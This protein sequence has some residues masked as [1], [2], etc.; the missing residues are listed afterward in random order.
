MK[1]AAFAFLAMLVISPTVAVAEMDETI[2]RLAKEELAVQQHNGLSHSLTTVLNRLGVPA[3]DHEQII[4]KVG[5][6]LAN[7]VVDGLA[8]D[9]SPIS[10][11]AILTISDGLEFAEGRDY[12]ESAYTVE[13]IDEYVNSY[14]RISTKCIQVVYEANNLIARRTA[15]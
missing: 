11:A 10:Q 6:E 5:H 1:T 7:C 13:E 15:T 3:E 4:Y 2:V 8:A 9:D 14:M 12:F